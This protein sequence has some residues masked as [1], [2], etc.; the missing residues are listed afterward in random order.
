MDSLLCDW[1][2]LRIDRV[3]PTED[4][5]ESLGILVHLF[6]SKQVFTQAIYLTCQSGIVYCILHDIT[7]KTH[8]QA[9]IFSGGSR[10]QTMQE[11][12]FVSGII[13]TISMMLILVGV[14][15]RKCSHKFSSI[16]CIFALLLVYVGVS[17]LEN[18]YKQKGWYGPS[19]RPPEHYLKGP[20]KIDQGNSI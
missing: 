5:L 3:H 6:S 17:Y 2:C 18:A 16:V 19:F 20:L 1:C 13:I 11:G 15:G 14:L 8:G 4:C 7:W 12:F 10:E 9:G